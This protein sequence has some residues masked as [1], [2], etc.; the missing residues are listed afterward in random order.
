[1]SQN[2]TTATV[3]VAAADQKTAQD[4]SQDCNGCF[5]SP[6]SADGSEPATH[7]F[8]NGMWDNDTLELLANQEDF[9]RVIRFGSNWAA[10]LEKEGLQ[11]IRPADPV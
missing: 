1:M 5:I 9:P 6:A 11:Y 10:A 4:F 7:F 3:I 2:W 8:T